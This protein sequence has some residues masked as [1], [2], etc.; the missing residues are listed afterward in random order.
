VR[1]YLDCFPCFL[2]QALETARLST[3]DENLQSLVLDRVMGVLRHMDHRNPPPVIAGVVYEAIKEVTH[4]TDPYQELKKKSDE[5]ALELYPWAKEKVRASR[6]PLKTAMCLACAANVVDFGIGKPFDLKRNLD[7][8]LRKGPDIDGRDGLIEA[9]GR[10][11]RLLYAG[12]NAGEIVLDKLLVEEIK[13]SFPGLEIQFAVRGAPVINDVTLIDAHRIGMGD[14]AR[15]I[16]TG[17]GMPGVC[18][19]ACSAGFLEN[20]ERADIV[21]AKGQGNYEALSSEVNKEIFF[22]LKA[23]CPVIAREL[24]VPVGSYII[25]RSKIKNKIHKPNINK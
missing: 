4:C 22:L 1:G 13:A 16:S 14:A 11:K 7:E 12:D 24:G 9:L 6:E 8:I 21:I 19:Q 5:I 15:V 23:K 20:Y 3:P 10:S 18:L 2:R 25:T 17:S